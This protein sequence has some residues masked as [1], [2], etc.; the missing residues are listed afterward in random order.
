MIDPKCIL[1]TGASSGLG[2]ALAHAY[3]RPGIRLCLLG[4]DPA[5]T[6]TVADTCRAR[7]AEVT[8]D[9]V[10]VTDAPA[11]TQAIDAADR[12]QPIDLLIANAGISG[13]TAGG[14]ES[15]DQTRRIL[16]TNVDGVLNTVAPLIEPMKRRRRGQIALMSSLASFRGLPGAPAYC[17]SKAWVRV[18]GEGLRVDL[19]PAG[20]EVS[21]ICPGYVD[22]P[23]TERN[24]FYMPL[25]MPAPRAAKIIVTG[26]QRNRSCIA[27]PRSAYFAIRLVA[28]LPPSIMEP[29]LRNTP[30]KA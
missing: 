22:T 1:I 4:R 17:A 11:L 27:F 2:A 19:A 15:T 13:G 18:W 9:T 7:G 5:R 10:D 20:V 25:M 29:M 28:A 8:S 16:A 21:I 3:A 24:D 23:M 26:L 14:S 6:A 30:R 12:Q